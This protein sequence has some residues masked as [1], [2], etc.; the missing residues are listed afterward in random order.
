LA[1]IW[2][3]TPVKPTRAWPPSLTPGIDCPRPSAPASSRWSRRPRRGTP[4]DERPEARTL[5]LAR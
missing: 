2:P 1:T 3:P 5:R 4:D